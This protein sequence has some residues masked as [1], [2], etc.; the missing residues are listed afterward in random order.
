M[1]GGRGSHLLEQPLQVGKARPVGGVGG[2]AAQ[3][4]GVERP[5]A[6]GRPRQPGP[7][8][9]QPLQDEVWRDAGPGLLA[10]G[11]HLPQRHPKHP[12]VRRRRE[13]PL[14]QALW[15]TPAETPLNRLPGALSP[16][17]RATSA[18]PPP[19]SVTS[20]PSPS[21][22]L[23]PACLGGAARPHCPEPARCPPDRPPI[24]APRP[25]TRRRGW[26]GARP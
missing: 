3:G 19:S 15:R 9:L 25:L 8:L 22:I 21:R 20:L 26:G 5:G 6:E 24:G 1:W 23:V 4:E 11:E 13:G 12:H 16:A 14:A 18:A 7:V 10:P 2:P 17:Q